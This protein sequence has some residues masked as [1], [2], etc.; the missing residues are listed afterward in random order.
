M[1]PITLL[2]ASLLLAAYTIAQ[3]IPS[4]P[5]GAGKLNDKLL[6]AVNSRHINWAKAEAK[7]MNNGQLPA[8]EATS[9][10]QAYGKPVNMNDGDIEALAFLVLMQAAKS[11]QEDIKGVM[12]SVKAINATKAKM[13]ETKEARQKLAA[14]KDIA[15][16]KQTESS[17]SLGAADIGEETGG[18]KAGNNKLSK[19][20][21]DSLY[22]TIGF[23][24][25]INQFNVRTRKDLDAQIAQMQKDIDG[26]SEMSE[27]QSL[28]LQMAMDRLN[29]MMSTLSNLQKKISSSADSVINNLK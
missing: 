6:L 10:A 15:R 25:H 5:E 16:L 21:L 3:Q 27:T 9:V 13:R 14:D 17:P 19:T 11:A 8:T 7:K 12:A 18:T 23:K 29:K 28:R 26:L 2:L 1:K 22:R 24:S 20:V 4:F